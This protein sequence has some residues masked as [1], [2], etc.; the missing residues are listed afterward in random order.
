M[1]DLIR[2]SLTVFSVLLLL[3][4]ALG[5]PGE[6]VRVVAPELPA[7]PPEDKRSGEWVLSVTRPKTDR[8]RDSDRII[9]R[10]HRALMPLAGVVWLDRAPDML[11]ALLVDYLAA[12]GA[13][14]AVGRYGDLPAP[15]RLDLDIRRFEI[16]VEAGQ[17]P[18]AEL[19]LTARLTATGR[20]LVA[21]NRFGRQADSAGDDPAQMLAAFESVLA[22]AFAELAGWVSAALHE[23]SVAPNN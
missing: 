12:N 8:T 13:F 5:R 9:V 15:Y 11:Q 4:C 22:A 2:V 14:V 16:R 6:S 10:R 1:R 23:D 7:S 20:G 19:Q 21:V 3:G 17:A 18:V